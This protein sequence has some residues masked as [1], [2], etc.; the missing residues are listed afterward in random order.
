MSTDRDL[1]RTVRS[2]L[3]EDQHE[4][5]DRVLD[6][7]VD[8]LDTTPQRRAVWLARRIPFMNGKLR[9][10]IAAGVVA[11]ASII[12]MSYLAS[13]NTGNDAPP[14]TTPTPTPEPSV[15]AS[16]TPAAGLPEG[17]FVLSDGSVGKGGRPA[18]VTIPAPGWHGEP[19]SGV[20]CKGE[21][22]CDIPQHMAGMIGPWFG[23]LYVYGDPC[24]WSSTKPDAP[25]S[26]VDELV[27]ALT[28]QQHRDASAPVDVTLGGYPGKFITL[29][30]PW[31][32][33]IAEC[34]NSSFGSWALPGEST[35]SR[36]H[37]IPAQVDELWIVDMDGILTVMDAYYF[38]GTSNQDLDELHAIIESMTFE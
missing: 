30:V 18:T 32:L 8:E 6:L 10:A 14:N 9:Y 7:V 33:S 16:P 23:N 3:H 22:A 13:S 20:L 17:Q 5:A 11:M 21:L 2:W 1:T 36:Y 38:S 31:N 34:D 37:Q 29:H 25:A 19:Q 27:A 35:P 4:D 26:T 15:A 28:A 24:E 12:G